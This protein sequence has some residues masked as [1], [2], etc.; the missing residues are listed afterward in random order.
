M[1]TVE[2]KPSSEFEE[3]L[4]TWLGGCAS[5]N[6]LDFI[7]ECVVNEMPD[8]VERLETYIRFNGNDSLLE[9]LHCPEAIED[10]EV[11]MDLLLVSSFLEYLVR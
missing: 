8:T 6:A 4:N 10:L 1:N 5:K 7:F 11:R 3:V 2:V 9:G